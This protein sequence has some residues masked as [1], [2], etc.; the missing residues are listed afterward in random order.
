[1]KALDVTGERYGRLVAIRRDGSLG[2]ESAWVFR[3]DCGQDYRGRLSPVRGGSTKSCGCLLKEAKGRPVTSGRF[4]RER[5]CLVYRAWLS[6]KGRCLNPN[7]PAHKHYA[8]RG[9]TICERWLGSFW[10]FAEDM[11]ERPENTSLGRIDVNGNYEPENCRWET[12][13]QQAR[14]RTDNVWIE[15]PDG[16]RV[17]FKDF[18]AVSGVSRAGL[19]DRMK[20]TGESALEAAAGIKQNNERRRLAA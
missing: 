2:K 14:S 8:G 13:A 12:L 9:I 5:P 6:M 15:M 19:L 18:V 17:V 20:R 1:M 10:A 16:R 4:R 11:G 3:C 7:H